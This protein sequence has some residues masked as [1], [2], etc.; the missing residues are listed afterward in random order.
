MLCV[1][2]NFVLLFKSKGI[3]HPQM[4]NKLL[5]YYICSPIVSYI[6]HPILRPNLGPS[7]NLRVSRPL[8]SPSQRSAE[9]MEVIYE[10]LL[11]IKAAAHL[12]TSVSL[13]FLSCLWLHPKWRPIP[14]VL[15][16][17]K[18][19]AKS[20]K[21]SKSSELYSECGAIEDAYSL[22]L[23]RRCSV[24]TVLHRSMAHIHSLRVGLLIKHQFCRDRRSS[25]FSC[26]GTPSQ[27]NRQPRDPHHMLA[28]TFR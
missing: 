19:P 15:H 5:L 25:T 4:D 2:I 1:C 8:Y 24:E 21:L 20:R 14:Y 3:F 10:E 18:A 17:H 22:S 6:N 11:H 9:D 26:P 16:Y 27:A 23:V 13:S 12:S 28:K 7:C